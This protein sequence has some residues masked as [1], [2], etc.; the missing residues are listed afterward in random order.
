MQC[1]Y[2]RIRRVYIYVH[3]SV[4]PCLYISLSLSPLSLSSC[5][6]LFRSRR[7]FSLFR[8][9]PSLFLCSYIRPRVSAS[10]SISGSCS[11][12]LNTCLSVGLSVSLPVCLSSCLFLHF[13][14]YWSIQRSIRPFMYRCPSTWPLYIYIYIHMC[15]YIY[16]HVYIYICIYIYIYMFLYMYIYVYTRICRV[17]LVYLYI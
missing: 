6:S 15:I 8:P 7:S 5:M 16:T 13:S 12:S 17:V 10:A 1:M 11:I 4:S 14:I 9:S 3:T 2:T